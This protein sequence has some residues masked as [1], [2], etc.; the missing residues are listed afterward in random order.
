MADLVAMLDEWDLGTQVTLGQAIHDAAYR[1]ERTNQAATKRECSQSRDEQ[2]RQSARGDPDGAV[3]HHGV[4]IVDVDAGLDREQ[5]VA[6]T[7]P[8]GI[9]ELRQFRTAR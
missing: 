6:L 9:T 1:T 5:L 7:K 4:D 8:A 3:A 2:S